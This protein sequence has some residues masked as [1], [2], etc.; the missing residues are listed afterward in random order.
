MSQV[1]MKNAIRHA[2]IAGFLIHG[3]AV[4]W[5]WRTWDPFGASNLMIWMGLPA[6]LAYSGTGG[7]TLFVCSIVFGGLEWAL[8]GGLV[9]WGVGRSLRRGSAG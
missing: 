8:L 7:A 9:A 5:I 4:L 1:Q 6:S 2:A 3:L